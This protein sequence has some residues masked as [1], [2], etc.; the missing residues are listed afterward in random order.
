MTQEVAYR[1]IEALTA[2]EQRGQLE[3]M[4]DTFAESCEIGNAWNTEKL[5]GVAGAREYWNAYRSAFREIRSNI[6][7]I[8][9]GDD[10]IALEWRARAVDRMGNEFH[11]DGV[12]II[13]TRG[14]SIT[15]FRAYFDTRKMALK[16][17]AHSASAS[18]SAA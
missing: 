4:L 6:L 8:V 3:P 16:I 1:F 7:H 10:S 18:A 17:P 13:E 15:R 9:I 2:L 5:Y 14:S 11:Y 12:S